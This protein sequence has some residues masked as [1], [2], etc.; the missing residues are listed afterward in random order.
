MRK[1]KMLSVIC[2]FLSIVMMMSFSGCNKTLKEEVF[3]I[4]GITTDS[5]E[6]Q[7]DNEPI[8]HLA[9]VIGERKNSPKPNLSSV[10]DILKKIYIYSGTLDIY[11]V[12]GDPSKSNTHIDIEPIDQ[13]L[14]SS[15]KEKKAEEKVNNLMKNLAEARAQSA[16]ADVLGTVNLAADKLQTYSEGEK[17]M[18]IFDSG[19]ST[20]GYGVLKFNPNLE[21]DIDRYI[22]YFKDVKAIDNYENIDI[23]WYCFGMAYGEQENITSLYTE[24]LQT[25]WT[26]IFTEGGATVSNSTFNHDGSVERSEKEKSIYES[27]PNVSAV[28]VVIKTFEPTPYS[29]DTD[30]D[31]EE[32]LDSDV[33]LEVEINFDS[34][35]NKI[36]DSDKDE[37]AKFLKPIADAIKSK[38]ADDDT[39]LFVI[40]C[41]SSF[42]NNEEENKK[43]GKERAEAVCGVLEEKNGVPKNK[44]CAIGAGFSDEN[45]YHTDVDANG[46]FVDGENAKKNRKVYVMYSTNPWAQKYKEN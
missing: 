46:N 6:N 26:K 39:Q 19:I 9:L 30:T 2:I 44:M 21:E 31:I 10:K 11:M 13:S 5:D 36:A 22:E 4:F 3:E 8:K 24:N 15:N 38:P 34:N 18:I 14:S 43:Y 29:P 20:V 23:T 40:G 25:I 16:E 7:E 33:V 12:D 28:D 1:N 35:V 27:Y 41:T 45:F 37:T 32:L 17:I 42:G